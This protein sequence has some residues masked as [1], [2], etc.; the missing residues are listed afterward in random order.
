M[1]QVPTSFPTAA[2]PI[3][4]TA[5]FQWTREK[6]LKAAEKN[7][8]I[9]VGPNQSQPARRFLTGAERKWRSDNPLEN[10]SIFILDPNYRISGNVN[11]VV[12]ALREASIDDATIQGLLNN[13]VTKQNYQDGG[14]YQALYDAEIA[15]RKGLSKAKSDIKSNYQL[16]D[17]VWFAENLKGA[18]RTSA[19]GEVIKGGKVVAGAGAGAGAG[20]KNTTIQ[21]KYRVLDENQVLDVSRIDLATGKG[22]RTMARPTK[23]SSTKGRKAG[24]AGVKLI[25]NNLESYVRALEL[26]F[27]PNAQQQFA[28]QIAS[29]RRQLA[30]VVPAAVQTTGFPTPGRFPVPGAPLPGAALAPPVQFTPVSQVPLVRTPGAGVPLAT[31]GQ[32]QYQQMPSLAG[33]PAFRPL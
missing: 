21:A 2:V 32:N 26:I 7:N 31:V 11:D 28:E 6:A 12:Q 14:A 18:D 16:K 19:T 20:G 22:Y 3:H 13:A 33:L 29:V 30:P 5:G 1:A 27:G 24:A 17:A 15:R 9:R 4:R 10:E 23:P 25:S 8:F